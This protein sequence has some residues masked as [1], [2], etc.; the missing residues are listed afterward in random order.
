[1]EPK[2]GGRWEGPQD[3][4]EG[5]GRSL[6]A[7]EEHFELHKDAPSNVHR[8]CQGPASC[9]SWGMRPTHCHVS[10]SWEQGL[11]M[12][13]F[14]LESGTLRLRRRPF[15]SSHSCG[16]TAADPWVFLSHRIF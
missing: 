2:A 6:K 13:L 14:I 10:V 9:W 16:S 5:L 1:M 11:L 4:R 15:S 12:F 7:A 3:P 8:T